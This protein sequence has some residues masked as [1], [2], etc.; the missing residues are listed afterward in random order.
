MSCP[1]L[2]NY[3]ITS[4]GELNKTTQNRKVVNF[5]TEIHAFFFRTRSRELYRAVVVYRLWLTVYVCHS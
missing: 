1:F 5:R 3:E 4:L 2:S